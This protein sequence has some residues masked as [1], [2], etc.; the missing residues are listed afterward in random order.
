MDYRELIGN[1]SN[2][3]GIG[4]THLAYASPY[5]VQRP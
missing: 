2:I 5:L 1:S 4:G 3:A